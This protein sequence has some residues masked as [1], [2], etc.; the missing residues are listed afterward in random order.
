MMV[1]YLFALAAVIAVIGV[2]S[3]FRKTID[4]LTNEP[5]KAAEA[6]TRFFSQ[7]AMVEI[8][9]LVLI[10]LA[11]SFMT[12]ETISISDAYIPI[13]I[14]IGTIVFHVISSISQRSHAQTANVDD[15]I[16]AQLQTFTFIKLAMGSS[17]PIVAL[18]F[19]FLSV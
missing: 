5:E 12:T 16:K 1:L 8:F 14:I 17:I 7:V 4:I 15:S 3:I 11:F 18:I 13:A 19:I 2:N 9:P 6:R 10:V